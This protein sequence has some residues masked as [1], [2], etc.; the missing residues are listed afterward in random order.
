MQKNILALHIDNSKPRESWKQY[1]FTPEIWQRANA[2][3]IASGVMIWEYVGE[4]VAPTI[5][6]VAQPIRPAALGAKKSGCG[7]G[8]K[9]KTT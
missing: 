1:V 5:Q 9:N 8:G 2:Q 3:Q 7:C 6:P 4:Q